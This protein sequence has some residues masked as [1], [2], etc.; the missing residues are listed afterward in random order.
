M[1]SRKFPRLTF[2]S[3]RLM[4][5]FPREALILETASINVAESSTSDIAYVIKYEA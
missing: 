5:L 4:L 1:L 3:L 2:Q